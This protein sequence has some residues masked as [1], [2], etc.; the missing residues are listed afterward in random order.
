MEEAR[1]LKAAG[2]LTESALVDALIG[3]RPGFV[4]AGLA[5]LAE[6][7]L[8][9]VEKI[10]SSHSPKG[11]TAIVWKAGLTMRFSVRLQSVVARIPAPQT[12]KPR[13]DGG[14]PLSE[15]ALSWQLGFFADMAA[16]GTQKQ[17]AV[18]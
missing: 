17:G 8:N 11:I 14:F 3:G 2:K 5:V 15:E 16:E 7:P 12:L 18:Q 10:L 1:R 6:Q 4:N 9:L 13:A